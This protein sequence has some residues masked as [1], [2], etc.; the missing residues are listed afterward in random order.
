MK[1][2]LQNII[3]WQADAYYYFY[4]YFYGDRLKRADV[5]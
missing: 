5:A 4:F 3:R 1:T 2:L